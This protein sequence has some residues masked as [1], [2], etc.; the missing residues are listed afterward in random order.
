MRT[1]DRREFLKASA[2]LT[3]AAAA[4]GMPATVRAQR[5]KSIVVV[6]FG[7]TYQEAQRKTYYEPFEA[8]T[9]IKVVEDT[10]PTAAK[11]KAMVDS[12]NVTWD[13]CE[14]ASANAL[15]LH[16]EGLLEDINWDVVPKD[17]LVEQAVLPGAVGIFNY[18]WVL[19]FNTKHFRKDGKHPRT[20]ADFWNVRDFPGPRALDA[21]NRGIAPLEFAVMADGVPLDKVYPI[22]VERGWRGLDRIKPAVVKWPTSFAQHMQ[23]LQDGE[24]AMTTAS[25]NRVVPAMK[26]GAPIDFVWNQGLL[27]TTYLAIPKGSKNR[28]EALRFIAFA[29]QAKPQAAMA[30]LQP[31]GP[32]NR[33]AFDLLTAE[34]A[35]VLATHKPNAAQ[36]LVLNPRWWQEPGKTGKS[37]YQEYTER[38]ASW[39][40]KK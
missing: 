21:G 30:K 19:A 32:V 7:G 8:A 37:H 28:A 25:S 17:D 1:V 3:V 20:W 23:L 33:K 13:V 12:Q 36:Q 34:E 14:F 40:I 11:I 29:T 10:I 5:G 16:K 27:D 9:G 4:L 15:T 24:V 38:F 39:V 26:A 35:S 18:S 31:G 22:D 2:S 6:S